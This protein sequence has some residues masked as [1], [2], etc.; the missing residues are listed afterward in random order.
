[1][2]IIKVIILK[3]EKPTYWYAGKLG[4][5]FECY[6]IPRGETFQ[7]VN[8]DTK[9]YFPTRFINIKDC[10]SYDTISHRCIKQFKFCQ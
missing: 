7:V 1:M 10:I 3:S 5:T 2:E 6:L 4:Q 9:H 8:K